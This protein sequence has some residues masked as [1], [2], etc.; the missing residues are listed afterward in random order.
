MI[1]QLNKQMELPF[2][3]NDALEE[4]NVAID[5]MRVMLDINCVNL[6][7]VCKHQHGFIHEVYSPQLSTN[8]KDTK[9]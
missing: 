1:Y 9:Y 8:R 3:Y 2:G 4:G 6:A 5:W 7:F